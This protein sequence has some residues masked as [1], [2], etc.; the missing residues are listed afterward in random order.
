MRVIGTVA[1]IHVAPVKALQ[2]QQRTSVT[3]TARGVEDD[4]RFCIVDEEGRM[5]NAKRVPAFVS[6]RPELDDDA[7]HLTLHMPDGTP[8]R[9]AVDLGAA[10][11]VSIYRRHVPAREVRGP[12]GDALSSLDGRT[13]RLVRFDEPGEGVDRAAEGGTATF[14]S[15]ASLDAMA[16]AAA[17]GGAVDPRRFRMLFGVAGVPAHAEDAWIGRRVSVGEVVILPQGN[18]GRCAVTTLD[19][20]RGVSDLDTLAALAAYR[21][22]VETTEALPF[23]VWGRVERAGTVRVGDAVTV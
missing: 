7:R 1:W 21:G 14:L 23:G 4:R 11:S 15:V 13:L 5:L 12:F 22:A 9:G 18:V 6:V 3:L 20:E 17:V 8:V 10:V 2:V 16:E 19:P